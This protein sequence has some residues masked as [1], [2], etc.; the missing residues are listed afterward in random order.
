MS[1]LRRRNGVVK[2]GI[3]A[4]KVNITVNVCRCRTVYTCGTVDNEIYRIVLS[5]A[6]M[7]TLEPGDCTAGEGSIPAR[8]LL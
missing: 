8:R 5:A 4:N 3:A 7:E 2:L 6:Y 1:S